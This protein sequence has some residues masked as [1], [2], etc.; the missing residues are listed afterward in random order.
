M[1]ISGVFMIPN[2]FQPNVSVTAPVGGSVIL[3]CHTTA[4]PVVAW[5]WL[6]QIPGQKLNPIVSTYYQEIKLQEEFLND[7]RLQFKVDDKKSALIFTKICSRDAAFYHC[8]VQLYEKL[9]FGGGTYLTVN[10]EW[11]AENV[12]SVTF[13]FDLKLCFYCYCCQY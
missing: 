4:N 8:G 9:Y 1:F 10:G 3:E 12:R 5:V 6:K 13:N 7:S 2:V 11:E